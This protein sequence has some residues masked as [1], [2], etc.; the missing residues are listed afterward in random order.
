MGM[1]ALVRIGFWGIWSYKQTYMG[2]CQ[3]S[4]PFWV[5]IITRQKGTLILTTTHLNNALWFGRSD[6]D[7]KTLTSQR[8]QHPLI[9]EYLGFL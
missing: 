4:G 1:G 5:P 8:A 6:T 3:Y 2:G 9:K 7:T